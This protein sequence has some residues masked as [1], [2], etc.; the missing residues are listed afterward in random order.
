MNNDDIDRRIEFLNPPTDA[1]E[2]IN[3]PTGNAHA[4]KPQMRGIFL[5]HERQIVRRRHN[6]TLQNLIP[7]SIK[8]NATKKSLTILD[9]GKDASSTFGN[10]RRS[11]KRKYNS[12]F[13]LGKFQVSSFKCQ[14]S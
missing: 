11:D 14:V 13:H 4:L 7:P 2:P 8:L 1:T 9:L 5:L 12:N 3:P 10:K 6:D